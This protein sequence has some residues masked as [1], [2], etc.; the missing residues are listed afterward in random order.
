ML[1]LARVVGLRSFSKLS[2][3]DFA[4]T[5]ALGAILVTTILGGEAHLLEGAIALIS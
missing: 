4:T 3:F 1:V 5:A 2:S